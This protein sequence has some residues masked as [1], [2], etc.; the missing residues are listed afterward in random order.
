[1]N[2]IESVRADTREFL[3]LHFH[4]IDQQATLD[5]IETLSALDRFSYI[6]TP[7]VDHMVNLHEGSDDTLQRV[8]EDA[9]LTVCDSQILQGLAKR[10]GIDLPLVTGSDLTGK[11]LERMNAEGGTIAV[12]GGD[13][14]LIAGLSALYRSIT[15]RQHIPP[16]GVRR[17]P[18]ARLDIAH[19]VENGDARIVLFAIGA[20][21]SEIVCREI[22]ERGKARGV[23][24]CI[25]ASLE[26][27]TGSKRRAPKMMQRLR[28]EWFF[29]LMSEPQRLWRRYLV[30][31]PKI[32]AIWRR[33][34]INR[35][36]DR[37]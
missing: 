4:P 34:S 11:L 21:Q 19:F 22:A 17:D 8:Y 10:S 12:I 5:A 16:M 28:L 32:F 30:Q 26:F 33:W 37:A 3:G 24:L 36:R 9:D 2:A 35:A 27:L 7:N 29:R 15:W 18:Q 31:G 25:G 13:A 1:M 14:Q 20:P 23:A 6:V